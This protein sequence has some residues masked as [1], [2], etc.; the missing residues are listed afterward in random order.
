MDIEMI[1]GFRAEAKEEARKEKAR[2]N[3]GTN[4]EQRGTMKWW[5]KN[6]A[7]YTRIIVNAQERAK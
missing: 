3:I 1:R 6:A 7:S 4:K 2:G 5:A